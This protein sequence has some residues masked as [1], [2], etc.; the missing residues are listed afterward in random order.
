MVALDHRLLKRRSLAYKEAHETTLSCPIHRLKRSIHA[1]PRGRA[2]PAQDDWQALGPEEFGWRQWPSAASCLARVSRSAP[3]PCCWHYVLCR[4]RSCCS[5]GPASSR[6][7]SQ[8]CFMASLDERDPAWT[9]GSRTLAI[10]AL[11]GRARLNSEEGRERLTCQS[12]STTLKSELLIL[13]VPL[14]SMNPSF[15][16][17]FMKKFTRERVVPI[18][19]ASTS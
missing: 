2:L 16:N 10:R 4:R 12:C 11:L 13:R 5:C 3:R 8:R 1:S 18:I 17:L 9:D 7:P 6:R 19:S 15:L 14:Y